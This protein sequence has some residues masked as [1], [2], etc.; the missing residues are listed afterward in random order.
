MHKKYLDFIEQNN[1]KSRTQ[2]WFVVNKTQAEYFTDVRNEVKDFYLSSEETIELCIKERLTS[3]DIYLKYRNKNDSIKIKSAPWKELDKTQSEYFTDIRSK[4]ESLYLNGDETLNLC[5][6]N[7]LISEKKYRDYKKKTILK[8][9]SQPWSL[10]NLSYV[11]F[12]SLV[13]E[14]IESK[15]NKDREYRPAFLGEFSE[16]NKKWNTSNSKTDHK[17]LN[18]DP[19]EWKKYH[20]LYTKLREAWGSDIPYKVIANELNKRP[21]WV[22]GD[23]GCGENLL[24]KEITNKVHAFDHIAIDKNVTSCDI[25]HVPLEDNTLDVV[26]FSLS[27][28]GTNYSEYF[29]EAHRV[30]K[31]MGVLMIAEPSTKWQD[32]EE[33]LK[34]KLTEAGFKLIGE[35]KYSERFVYIDA[36]KY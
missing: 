10:L 32:K 26:V 36:I 35:I 24:S 7:N 20:N 9:S 5:V 2:P 16:M 12:F 27:L 15:L 22:V 31:P 13:K 33:D 30:L 8:L 17:R 19:T 28:M 11:D 29:K 4:I 34:T 25:T 3:L 14:T 23:F 6:K 18:A 21:D 1:I